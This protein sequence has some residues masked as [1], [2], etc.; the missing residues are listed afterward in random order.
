MIRV[1]GTDGPALGFRPWPIEEM[2]ATMKHLPKAQDDGEKFAVI[3]TDFCREVMPTWPELKRLLTLHL[4]PTNFYKIRVSLE[5]KHARQNPRFDNADNNYYSHALT[6]Q[7]NT[8]KATFP[9]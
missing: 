1:M 2:K 4:G 7:C 3:L 8:L 6:V 5:G 9:R